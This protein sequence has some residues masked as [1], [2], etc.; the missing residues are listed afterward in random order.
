MKG[1]GKNKKIYMMGVLEKA[2]K[3]K[4]DRVKW[5]NV[6]K[7][8]KEE[9]MAFNTGWNMCYKNLKKWTMKRGKMLNQAAERELFEVNEKIKRLKVHQKRIQKRNKELMEAET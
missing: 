3:K 2:T 6:K 5:E 7:R 4:E 1:S 8:G 9:Q